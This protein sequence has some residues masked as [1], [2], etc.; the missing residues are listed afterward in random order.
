LDFNGDGVPQNYIQEH[1]W[2]SLAAANALDKDGR[3]LAARNRELVAS[4]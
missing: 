2:L 4:K 1:M 3:D